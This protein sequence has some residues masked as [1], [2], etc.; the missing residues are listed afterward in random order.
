MPSHVG[1]EFFQLRAFITMLIAPIQLDFD[2]LGF[3]L[4][5]LGLAVINISRNTITI[6]GQ[7]SHPIEFETALLQSGRGPIAIYGATIAPYHSISRITGVSVTG[8]HRGWRVLFCAA[9]KTGGKY[10]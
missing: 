1:P 6:R 5:R 2:L 10:Y 3:I 8:R 9:D 4:R 7:R